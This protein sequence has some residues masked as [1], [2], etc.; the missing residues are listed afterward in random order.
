M[1]IPSATDTRAERRRL[2]F[3]LLAMLELATICCCFFAAAAYSSLFGYTVT[4]AVLSGWTTC[5]R[6][7]PLRLPLLMFFGGC[8]AVS[9]G[10][11]CIER[12][13]SPVWTPTQ[14]THLE[15]LAFTGPIIAV[16]GAFL[17]FVGFVTTI[18]NVCA[19]PIRSRRGRAT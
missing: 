5:V 14:T 12:S 13:F 18:S 1:D 19:G 4:F 15:H 3:G 7:W 9:F 2:Q 16:F 8:S 11:L 6:K 10:L 17:T